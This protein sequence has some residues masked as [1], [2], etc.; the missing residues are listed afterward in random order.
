[1]IR[2]VD[3]LKFMDDTSACLFVYHNSLLHVIIEYLEGL[4]R[5]G[6]PIL[7][8]EMALPFAHLSASY[9]ELFQRASPLRSRCVFGLSVEFVLA[10]YKNIILSS[11]P[12][13]EAKAYLHS[14]AA[15]IFLERR[16]FADVVYALAPKFLDLAILKVEH[17]HFSLMDA[18]IF[19]A[20]DMFMTG[21]F[22]IDSVTYFFPYLFDELDVLVQSESRYMFEALSTILCSLCTCPGI[23]K[24]NGEVFLPQIHRALERHFATSKRVCIR[25]LALVSRIVVIPEAKLMI[26]Y[27]P[28]L[29]KFLELL[30]RC[31]TVE[32][33][34][35]CEMLT[36]LALEVLTSLTSVS[37]TTNQELTPIFRAAT[38]AIP[39]RMLDKLAL[40]VCQ[41][42]NLK[43][44]PMLEVAHPAAIRMLRFA[45]S[46]PYF[47]Q[48]LRDVPGFSLTIQDV[49]EFGLLG[50]DDAA[51]DLIELGTAIA[52]FDTEFAK[53]ILG[54]NRQGFM[55]QILFERD[56][57]A[58]GRELLQELGK[59]KQLDGSGVSLAAIQKV[60]E[61]KA[62]TY[63]KEKLAMAN[64][65]SMLKSATLTW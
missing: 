45:C 8:A 32:V 42:L 65:P 13:P 10:L 64:P 22:G 51:C 14:L 25:L 17:L 4:M 58:V 33:A 54:L 48:A 38:E 30:L 36:V 44:Q 26:L 34:N 47:V 16:R 27:D 19:L 1:V 18:F 56:V 39:A 29:D 40:T 3:G 61:M 41:L 60:Y 7:D 59:R 43:R 11:P 50:E 6:V 24:A 9:L 62:E 21:P 20:A 15:D 49:A 31:I 57:G 46:S 35:E 23:L 12:H 5:S 63:N 52:K 53:R 37:V 2:I 28:V 55:P